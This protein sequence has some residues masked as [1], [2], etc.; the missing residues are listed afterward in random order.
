MRNDAVSPF[1]ASA[2]FRCIIVFRLE[3]RVIASLALL[4]KL[5]ALKH[6]RAFGV[7]GPLTRSAQLVPD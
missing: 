7:V 6:K 3:L 5:D 1:A 4:P 2:V